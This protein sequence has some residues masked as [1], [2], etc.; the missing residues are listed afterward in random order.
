MQMVVPTSCNFSNIHN[1]LLQCVC[2]LLIYIYLILYSL[3]H[4]FTILKQYPE[5]EQ[6]KMMEH[7][8]DCD[9]VVYDITGDQDQINESTWAVS[10]M[11]ILL[12]VT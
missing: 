3:L 10:G 1:T 9:I 8:V 6:K 7:L 2:Q 5:E 4:A 12:S 11:Y